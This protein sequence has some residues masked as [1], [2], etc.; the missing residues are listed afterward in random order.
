MM[1]EGFP[2]LREL[3]IQEMAAMRANAD[4]ARAA[5]ET[6]GKAQAAFW[7]ALS[8]EHEEF[9]SQTARQVGAIRSFGQLPLTVVGA[10]EPDL[11]FGES[12]AAFRHYWNDES[13]KLAAKS[14]RGRFILAEGSS[15]QIHLDAPRLVIN[16]IRELLQ[17]STNS[18]VPGGGAGWSSTGY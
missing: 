12:S 2:E 9:F 1:G 7:E 14:E 18:F 8:S 10:T 6:E 15:H 13:Q 4:A 5:S 17:E 16:A 11:R 3:F